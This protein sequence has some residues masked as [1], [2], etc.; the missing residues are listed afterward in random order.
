MCAEESAYLNDMLSSIVVGW[1]LQSDRL[2]DSSRSQLVV[3]EIIHFFGVV[4]AWADV[5]L[6]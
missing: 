3:L 6:A 2:G 5:E 1:F 4:L